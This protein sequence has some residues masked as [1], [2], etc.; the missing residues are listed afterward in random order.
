MKTRRGSDVDEPCFLSL[1][2]KDGVHDL[3]SSCTAVFINLKCVGQAGLS[4]DICLRRADCEDQS[5]CNSSRPIDTNPHRHSLAAGCC[6]AKALP[7][8]LA[9]AAAKCTCSTHNSHVPAF[10]SPHRIN[11]RSAHALT[12]SVPRPPPLQLSLPFR[13]L[14]SSQPLSFAPSHQLTVRLQSAYAMLNA[15]MQFFFARVRHHGWQ[16]NSLQFPEFGSPR[17]IGTRPALY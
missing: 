5:I 11:T 14:S 1:S 9:R 4:G 17:V 10:L 8:I 16:P 2:M 7:S 12:G 3:E 15:T 6:E 13:A